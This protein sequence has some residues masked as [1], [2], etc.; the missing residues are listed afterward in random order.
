MS[1]GQR[2]I[3]SLAVAFGL[4]LT[5][6]IFFSIV[7]GLYAFTSMFSK[8]NVIEENTSILL[9]QSTENIKYLDIDVNSSNLVIKPGNSFIIETNNKHIKYKVDNNELKIKE[10]GY[11]LTNSKLKSELII[12]IPDT[13]LNEI[14]INTG[15][16]NL[17]IDSINTE[18]LDID[19]GTGTTLINNLYSKRAD[20]DTGAGNL[21]IDSI[22]TEKLDIDLGTGTTL[23]NNLYS[24]R[25]DID[26]GAGTFTINNGS[27]NDLDLDIGIGEVKITS[28]IT[29][30]SSI[31]SGVG[32]LSLNLLNTFDNYRFEVNK[33][34][35]KV[36]INDIEVG[37]NSTL[38]NGTNTIKLDGGIGEIVVNFKK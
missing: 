26:T 18:K 9:N 2:I 29:G 7:G 35:G 25:A 13:N 10:E 11:H 12:T 20:I 1:T 14:D 34:I 24:K 19:L 4:F 22:N 37:D 8:D 28:N 32:K 38:G 5:F 23:I 3:K 27:I 6:T 17:N 30:N 31:S 21:N 16:G 36:T 33:G 15:A